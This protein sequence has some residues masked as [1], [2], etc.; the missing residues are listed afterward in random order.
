[1]FAAE[2]TYAARVRTGLASLASG[3]AAEVALKD[4]LPD[5]GIRAAGSVLVLLSAFC[6]GAAIWRQLFK[7]A[8][9]PDVARIPGFVLY[10]V[11][12]A[13]AMVALFALSSIWISR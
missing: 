11:N 9:P 3:I 8:P 10:A 13:L 2:R 1:M 4:I 12:G 6:F 7:P 5:L